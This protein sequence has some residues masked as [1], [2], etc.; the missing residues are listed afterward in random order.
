MSPP[1]PD[2]LGWEETQPEPARPG[3]ADRRLPPRGPRGA[4]GSQAGMAAVSIR[5]FEKDLDAGSLPR[6]RGTRTQEIRGKQHGGWGQCDCGPATP[7]GT[8]WLPPSPPPP[9]SRS[10]S[11][12]HFTAPAR[13]SHTEPR[14]SASLSICS[15]E[16]HPRSSRF[17]RERP[18]DGSL[19]ICTVTSCLLNCEASGTVLSIKSVN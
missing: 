12:A 9:T 14:G 2:R 10:A 3:T 7:R 13:S 18:P 17:S 11:T 8:T 16:Q 1:H 4:G 5:C 6:L 15:R 19:T